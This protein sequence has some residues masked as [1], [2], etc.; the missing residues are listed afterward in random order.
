MPLL[1][2]FICIGL[3]LTFTLYGW[4]EY[5]EPSGPKVD[6]RISSTPAAEIET[7]RPTPAPP[8]ALGAA[9]IPPPIEGWYDMPPAQFAATVERLWSQKHRLQ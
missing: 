8:P 7:F 5:L 4:S 2:Y 6:K 3:L 1:K 9:E